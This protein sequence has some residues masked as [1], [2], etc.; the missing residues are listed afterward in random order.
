MLAAV[1]HVGVDQQGTFAELREHH[2]QIGGQVTAAFAA[3]GA[4]DG[5]RLAP[6]LAGEPAQHELAAQGAQR[7]DLRAVGLVGGHHFIGNRALAVAQVGVAVLVGQRELKVVFGQQAE[8]DGGFAEADAL[9][10]LQ[11]DDLFGVLRR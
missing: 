6:G 7:F 1:T 9:L 11:A 10:L 4:D 5:E 8:L 3:A 2:G